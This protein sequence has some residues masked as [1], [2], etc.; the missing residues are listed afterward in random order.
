VGEALSVLALLAEA[1][2]PIRIANAPNGETDGTLRGWKWRY[3]PCDRRAF[4]TG[5]AGS[6]TG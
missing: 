2:V 3:G 1:G 4:H 6:S 5:R